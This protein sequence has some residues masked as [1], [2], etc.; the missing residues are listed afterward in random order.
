MGSSSILGG[1]SKRRKTMKFIA[2]PLA[3]IL[4][5]LD[6]MCHWYEK[7]TGYVIFTDCFQA[8]W[9]CKLESKYG[10]ETKESKLIQWLTK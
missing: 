9:V 10:F 6:E 3:F 8:H 2:K 4:W 1:G 7:N 5:H